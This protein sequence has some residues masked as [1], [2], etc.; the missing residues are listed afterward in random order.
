MDDIVRPIVLNVIIKEGKILLIKRTLGDYVD[1]F[2]L[3]GG[4]IEIAEHLSGSA[5]REA[6]EETRLNTKFK[7]LLGF[8][9]EHL[10]DEDNLKEHFLLY[11][12]EME[13]ISEDE[14]DYDDELLEWFS[15]DKLKDSSEEI[16]PSDMIMIE[17]FIQKRD[18][19]FFECDMKK[20]GNRYSIQSI[21]IR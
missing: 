10:W 16:I 7:S 2:G 18:C 21:R 19:F 11:V 12:C 14:F 3:P 17:H 4:K 1:Y 8:V 20:Q 13:L 15:L 9:S 5:E 6:Y